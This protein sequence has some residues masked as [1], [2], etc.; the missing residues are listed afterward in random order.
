MGCVLWWLSICTEPLVALWHILIE[1]QLDVWIDHRCYVNPQ[2]R[3]F[4]QTPVTVLLRLNRVAISA[5]I[6]PEG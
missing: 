3:D 5:G 1:Q 4:Y 6:L 2:G